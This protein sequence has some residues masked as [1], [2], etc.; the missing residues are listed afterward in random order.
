MDYEKK[1]IKILIIKN[2]KANWNPITTQTKNI[3]DN[4]NRKIKIL[5]DKYFKVKAL[6][7]QL[8]LQRDNLFD[9]GRE[10]E[11][12]Y[13]DTKPDIHLPT[14]SRRMKDSILCW[15]AS[16]FFDDIFTQGSYVLNKLL[17]ISKKSSNDIKSQR[18]NVK[19]KQRT[20]VEKVDKTQSLN[21]HNIQRMISNNNNFQIIQGS[22]MN[23]EIDSFQLGDESTSN[24][25]FDT[26]NN[27]NQNSNI[28]DLNML[29]F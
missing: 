7:D 23:D 6:F 16:N 22:R 17:Q 28:F 3:R 10:L 21:E 13:S 29:N 2:N 25:N 19:K 26:N 5:G 12:V 1:E 24:S 8:N 15:Y 9:L 27:N 14:S 20:K 11:K 18:I 4:T